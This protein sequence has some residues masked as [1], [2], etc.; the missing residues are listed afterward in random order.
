VLDVNASAVK[1]Y[2]AI[3]AKVPD[4]PDPHIPIEIIRHHLFGADE[5]DDRLIA[6]V[7]AVNAICVNDNWASDW[8]PFVSVVLSLNGVEVDPEMLE[9]PLVGHLAC[10]FHMLRD[11]AKHRG[12]T[13]PRLT[14]DIG[15]VVRAACRAEG[16]L[17]YPESLRE[18]EPAYSVE[19]RANIAL[20]DKTLELA[21][22]RDDIDWD[23][24]PADV[25]SYN[26]AKLIDIDEYCDSGR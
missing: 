20:I 18:F 24:F 9:P 22:S 23:V 21:K 10:A 6:K 11:L 15:N 5:A 19:D 4:W 13:L 3:K 26:V 8:L 12:I 25:V 17:R 2:E 16:L 7:Q 1:I 14:N